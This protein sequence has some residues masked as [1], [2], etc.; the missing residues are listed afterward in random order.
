MKVRRGLMLGATAVAVFLVAFLVAGCSDN[1]VAPKSDD[2]T[3]GFTYIKD[4]GGD[5][6]VAPGDPGGKALGPGGRDSDSAVIG[7]AGG[8]IDL[9]LGPHAS[10]FLVPPGALLS[11]VL[12]S[13]A[14][15][16]AGTPF[17]DVAVFDFGPDGLAFKV[18]VKLT[19]Q[20][21]DPEGMTKRLYWWNPSSGRWQL[22]NV[23]PVKDGEV[24][25]NVAHFSKYGITSR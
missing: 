16:A 4:K 10:R 22:V 14:A 20:V 5:P 24:T 21:S 15:V 8:E 6:M 23:A 12:I 17:G 2:G 19:L 11:P 9:T 1:P 13:V 18:P 25:F 3:G 7:P